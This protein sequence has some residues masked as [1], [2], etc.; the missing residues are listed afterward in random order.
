M[1]AVA[2]AFL[3]V[4]AFTWAAANVPAQD[5]PGGPKAGEWQ[6]LFDGRSLEGWRET[7]FTNHGE[8]RVS[9]GAIVLGNGY[10]TGITWTKP[11]PKVNYDLRLEA[12]RVQGGDFFAGITFPVQDSFC[13]WI[14]GG[15]GGRLV[16]LS[17]LDGSD[18]SENETGM[19]RDFENGRWYRLLLRV[20][21]DRIQAWID[22]D[23][24][25]DVYT[26]NRDVGLRPGEIELS[27]PLGIASYSTVAKLRK[28]EYRVLAPR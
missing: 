25:I 6:A 24:V 1:R 4:I 11:F 14:N 2:R 13:S 12:M 26:G 5:A 10:M 28:I 15:W 9:D 3:W 8:V 19:A 22:D 27:K 17:S 18:A 16:G 23:P 21:A 20:T 7:P